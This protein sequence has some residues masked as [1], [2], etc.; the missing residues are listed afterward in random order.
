MKNKF[1]YL[2]AIAGCFSLSFLIASCEKDAVASQ[3]ASAMPVPASASFTEG[4]D[5][6]GG[7]TARGWVFRNNSVPV[8]QTSWRQG[9]Y[10]AMPLVTPAN[11]KGGFT[12]PVP[13][14]GFPAYSATKS[15]QDFL[16]CDITAV[17]DP[18]GTGGNLSAWL[19]SPQVAMKNGDQISFYTRAVDDQYYPV[20]TK[21]RLQVWI[22]T[23][24]GSAN[25]GK[26]PFTTGS[27]TVLA[28]DI[29]PD[30]LTN[31]PTGNT[32]GMA[33]Y[34]ETWTKYT[35]TVAGLPAAGITNGRFALRYYGEDAGFFGGSSASNYPSLIG[36]DNLAFVHN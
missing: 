32:N 15:P 2:I 14:L 10:E 6:V 18:N 31:D 35:I 3:P 19:I 5:S 8:G 27:F 26:D 33:G 29:N 23:T 12:G 4:F 17:S 34:P 11:K 13:F 21:D 16:S 9:R 1:Y 36:I 22:N 7:L 20:Y 30:Y 28:K 25:V 24:D